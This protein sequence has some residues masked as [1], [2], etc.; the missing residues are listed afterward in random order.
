MRARK[1]QRAPTSILLPPE[2]CLIARGTQMPSISQAAKNLVDSI[3]FFFRFGNNR[4]YSFRCF[5]SFAALWNHKNN[6]RLPKYTDCAPSRIAKS[7][8]RALIAL[9]FCRRG[10]KTIK[11]ARAR[12]QTA[13]NLFFKM[14]SLEI[15]FASSMNIKMHAVACVGGRLLRL[16]TWNAAAAMPRPAAARAATLVEK[17]TATVA[18]GSGYFRRDT[19]SRCAQRKFA[20]ARVACFRRARHRNIF[21]ARG[22][23]GRR[24]ISCR[25]PAFDFPHR[26]ASAIL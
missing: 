20:T 9:K 4:K 17:S 3:V 25:R 10:K 12:L 5:L 14:Q 22:G 7:H 21:R 6:R 1:T 18:G 24:R 15:K 23:G 19:R 13:A 8:K 26:I 2:N 16:G 11:N